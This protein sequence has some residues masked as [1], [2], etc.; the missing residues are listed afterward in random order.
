MDL[1]NRDIAFL[2]WFGAAATAFVIAAAMVRLATASTAST[3]TFY[4]GVVLAIAL[5]Y[6][7]IVRLPPHSNSDK[8]SG[9]AVRHAA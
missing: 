6:A 2:L 3:E 8:R 9:R 7:A 1:T 4:M 5:G